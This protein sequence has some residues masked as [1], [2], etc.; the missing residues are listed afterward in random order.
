MLSWLLEHVLS[1]RCFSSRYRP[2][3]LD[4]LSKYQEF[5]CAW[6]RGW[7]VCVASGPKSELLSNAWNE[8]SEEKYVLPKQEVWL[9]RDT[10]AESSMVREPGEL[11][12]CMVFCSVRFYGDGIN[13][14]VVCPTILTHTTCSS[15]WCTHCSAEM[16]SGEEDST[17]EVGRTC[18]I[19][20]WFSQIILSVPCSLPGPPVVK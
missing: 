19:S 6:G 13:F 3:S 10:Q 17:W 1:Y 18:G 11:L 7:G 9:G 12:C 8:L 16:D 4:S 20:F 5:C 14:R 2:C 15:W